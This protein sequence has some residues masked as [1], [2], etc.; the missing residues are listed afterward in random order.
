MVV[1]DGVNVWRREREINR[2]REVRF[3]K[4]F[5]LDMMDGVVVV[6]CLLG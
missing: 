6:T 2:D 4:L 1:L 5:F 3:F